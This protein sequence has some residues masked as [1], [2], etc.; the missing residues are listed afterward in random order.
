MKKFILIGVV[1]VVVLATLAYAGYAYAQEAVE[2]TFGPGINPLQMASRM[3]GQG[4]MM[5]RGRGGRGMGQ[6]GMMGDQAQYG[7]V[8]QTYIQAA[9]ADALGMTVDELEAAQAEGKNTWQLAEEQGLTYSEFQT[10]LQ[11]AQKVQ[12]AKAVKDGVLTQAQADAVLAQ[13]ENG[14]L[15]GGFGGMMG[16]GGPG[17][18]GMGQGQMAEYMHAAL[19]DALDIS[20][21]DLEAAISA[22]KSPWDLAQD[23]GLTN[24][25]FQA[26]MQEAHK[27]ALAKMVEA[28]VITQEQADAMLDRMEN[29]PMG[30]FGGG[31][32]GRM[33]PGMGPGDCPGMGP[34]FQ[35]PQTTPT[36]EGISG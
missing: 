32:G 19:A 31:R 33:G 35:N 27:T 26:L 7:G 3:F 25:E 23:K 12:V 30:G 34:G 16:R 29:A 11:A 10:K 13:L 21:A 5:G 1:A 18:F 2:T 8:L 36:T 15:G 22:G 4:G 6:G 20:E 24:E 9:L 17:G 14:P 28:G